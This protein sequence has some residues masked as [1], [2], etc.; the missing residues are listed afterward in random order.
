VERKEDLGCRNNALNIGLVRFMPST[1]E[2]VL[3][4]L[5][6][7]IYQVVLSPIRAKKKGHKPHSGS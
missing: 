4:R 1:K 6:I 5:S 7:L 2:D 3:G